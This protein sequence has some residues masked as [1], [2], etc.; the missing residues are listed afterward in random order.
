[1]VAIGWSRTEQWTGAE[2]RRWPAGSEVGVVSNPEQEQQ[3]AC[4]EQSRGGQQAPS[5]DGQ[6]LG[7]G[8]MVN[9]SRVEW[10]QWAAGPEWTGYSSQQAQSGVGTVVNGPRVEWV[11]WPAGLE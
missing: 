7:A 10:V 2:Q 6:Q 9:T 1:M 3:P 8:T 5:G 11:Q 4:L